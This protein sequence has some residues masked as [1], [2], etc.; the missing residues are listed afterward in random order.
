MSETA[1]APR[2][3]PWWLIASVL[4]NC[5]LIG[6]L[7]GGRIAERR[8]APETPPAA[9]HHRGE[10]RLARGLLATLPE[11]DRREVGRIFFTSMAA[12]RD[13]FE[14]RRDARS[15]LGE[16]LALDPYDETAVRSALDSLQAA[17][18]NLQAALQDTLADQLAQLSPEQRRALGEMI[19][20][21]DRPGP[22]RGR[23]GDRLP[24]PPER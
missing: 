5:L 17:D 18:R 4:L 8:A 22:P 9:A 1:T 21:G 10:M 11:A 13:L 16:A 23:R 6:V 24:P 15:A 12:N 14:A 2:R 19:T 7:V 3:T 20:E